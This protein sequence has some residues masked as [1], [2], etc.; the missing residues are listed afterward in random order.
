[1]EAKVTYNKVLKKIKFY[2]VEKGGP[3]IVGRDWL[4][5]FNVNFN[6]IG[7][8]NIANKLTLLLDEFKEVFNE[9][10]GKHVGVSVSIELNEGAKPIFCKARTLPLAYKEEVDKQLR[11]MEEEGIISPIDNSEWATPLVPILKQNGEIR[12]CGDYKTTINKYVKDI[13]YPLPRVEE[14]FAKIGYGQKF[15]KIDLCRA[16]NQFVVDDKTSKL[17][18]WNTHRGLYRVKRMPFGIK[19]ATS[20]F[21]KN[22]EILV[23]GMDGVVVFLDDILV[24]G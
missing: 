12:I 2:V 16:Y 1:M 22:M 24:T 9:K 8:I 11:K 19:V 13:K 7:S 6:T 4:I 18:A 21:Q 20:I 10:L 3:N 23:N 17:L 14:I 15:S 5:K